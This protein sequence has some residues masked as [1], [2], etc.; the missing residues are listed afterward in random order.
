[1]P[2]QTA[3][4]L[5]PHGRDAS[6]AVAIL[7][8]A[9]IMAKAVADIA[10]L[11]ARLRGGAGFAIVT[12]DALGDADLRDLAS[13]IA[14]QKEWSDFPFI[15]LTARGGGLERNP[16]A[17]RLLESLGNVTF[18]ERPF[19]PTTLVSLARSALRARQ[20]QYKA[21]VLLDDVREGQDRMRVALA[22]GR[23]GAWSV[24]L[25]S[26]EL[27]TAPDCKA[28]FGRRG[29]E[30]FAY[31]DLLAS[32]H[33][34]DIDRMRGMVRASVESGCD[35]DIQYRCVWLDGSIHWVQVNGRLERDRR[36]RPVRMVGVSQDITARKQT[37][38]RRAALLALG[39]GLRH[40]TTPADMSFLAAE[41]LGKTLDASRAGYGVIDRGRESITIDRDWTRRGTSSVAGV[42]RFREYG[43][44]INDLRRG[45]V[46]VIENAQSDPRTAERVTALD[47][48]KVRAL[49]NVPVIDEGQFVALLY[50]HQDKVRVWTRDEL[51]FVRDVA[52]RTQA[53][54]ERRNAETALA[55]LANSLERQ[56]EERTRERDRTW[57]NS[58]DLL[59]VVDSGGSFLAVNPA[60]TGILGWRPEEVIGHHHLDFSHPDERAASHAAHETA[61]NGLLRQHECRVRHADGSYRWISW[62]ASVDGD[63]VYASGRHITAEKQAQLQLEAAQ[64]QL[65]QAQKMEAVGQ[66]TGGLAHDFNNL[67]TG[68]SGGLELIQKRIKQ[69]RIDEIDKYIDM[70]QAA[71]K[72]AAALTHRL[73]AFSRRQTLDP[74]PTHINRL[75]A[76]MEEFLQRSIGPSIELVVT[77]EPKLWTT[78]IDP[79]QLENALLNLCLNARD[80]MPKGG[81]ITIET[82]NRVLD[83]DKA[84]ERDLPAGQYVALCVTDNGTGMSPETL[85]RAFDPFFTTKPLGEGT[86]LGLSMIYGFV[87]QSGGQV[88][89]HSV[90]GEGTRICLYLPFVS[91]DEE[92][93]PAHCDRTESQPSGDG[94]TVLVVDDEPSVRALV[95]DVLTDL[96][97]AA[98][99]AEDGQS[100]FAKL[101]LQPRIDLLITDV[102]LPRGMNGRQLADAARGERPELKVLFITGFAENA[103]IG[104]ERLAPGMH[105]LTKPFAIDALANRIRDLIANR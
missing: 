54:I 52:D 49:I 67:L 41:I 96:G 13:F 83:P 97:Y 70:A 7:R 50:I 8:E 104:N 43:T 45:S 105:I 4:V 30:P 80:A 42:H 95:V 24:D 68:M 56:V 17:V 62:V 31:D 77:G 28:Q 33:P 89:I 46:V 61:R 9:E 85:A 88:R 69:G 16:G 102:G 51:T 32:I 92:E 91:S 2:E 14:D 25:K 72:R 18:L 21:Q 40:L 66:L 73:L 63:Q 81:R 48:L 78:L 55:D 53:A 34:D 36:G 103:V 11:T 93:L 15:V 101:K 22:A 38:T 60:W 86:G 27:V 98:I 35:Y 76:G 84:S 47:T 29:N 59:A 39:D 23:L 94:E 20:R 44:F 71:A 26:S 87:R 99:E 75:I 10:Q 5:A 58:Q 1:M 57:L 37:E 65:R 3:I 6:V 82:S 74:R 12:E 64:E 19:H 79:N 90:P 100:G